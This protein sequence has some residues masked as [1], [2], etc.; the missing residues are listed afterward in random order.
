MYLREF[1]DY[2]ISKDEFIDYYYRSV[3]MGLTVCEDA[4]FKINK[5]KYIMVDLNNVKDSYVKVPSFVDAV[6]S[7]PSN[8][9]TWKTHNKYIKDLDLNNVKTIGKF[10]LESYSIHTISGPN[11]VA[12]G[13]EGFRDCSRLKDIYFPKVTQVAEKAFYYC[14]NIRAIHL[15]SLEVTGREWLSNCYSLEYLS[16][17]KLKY[18]KYLGDNLNRH[19]INL[20]FNTPIKISMQD[21]VFRN[22]KE[23]KL[24]NWTGEVL[25]D[26][27]ENSYKVLIP[28]KYTGS[29][30]RFYDMYERGLLSKGDFKKDKY[31]WYYK[32]FD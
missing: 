3:A 10:G 32:N 8:T 5:Y 29:L 4:V 14:S 6:V 20:D 17:P 2:K 28:P 26:F 13:T 12:I 18:L 1:N 9:N 15:P 27:T 23:D 16:V 11:L 21:C 30:Y 31:G 22:I 19:I 25:E 24:F 7:L